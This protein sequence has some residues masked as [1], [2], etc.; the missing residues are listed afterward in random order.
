MHNFEKVNRGCVLVLTCS[1][2][3]NCC[4][5][6]RPLKLCPLLYVIPQTS[7]IDHLCWLILP[8]RALNQN[9]CPNSWQRKI[10]RL[11][12]TDKFTQLIEAIMP[13]EAWFLYVTLRPEM[14][15]IDT[16]SQCR[17]QR[18]LICRSK[19][20]IFGFRQNRVLQALFILFENILFNGRMWCF[21]TV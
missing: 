19:I 11:F 18:F 9:V 1:L 12:H 3:N 6:F 16:R 13:K 10:M 17:M 15:H 5:W 4:G 7:A 21:M 2:V 14:S 20:L 8:S